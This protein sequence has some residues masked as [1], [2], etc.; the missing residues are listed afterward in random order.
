MRKPYFKNIKAGDM[1]RNDIEFDNANR[2]E[3]ALSRG[4]TI[5]THK[6]HQIV[7]LDNKSKKEKDKLYAK[8]VEILD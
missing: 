8:M 4:E 6:R 2:R 3:G 7:H 1:T 5:G